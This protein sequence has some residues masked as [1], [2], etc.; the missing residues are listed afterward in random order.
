MQVKYN[1]KAV[2]HISST[3]DYY[4]EH[5]GKQATTN[6]AHEIDEKVKTLR[7]YPEIGFPEPLLKDRYIPYRATIIGRYHKLIYYVRGNTLR[8]AALWD[9]RMHPERLKKR[10]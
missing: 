10:I 3:I 9:M 5:Y 4:L 2:Q 8:I 7:K 1:A 6:L